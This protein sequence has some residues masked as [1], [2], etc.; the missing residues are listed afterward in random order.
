MKFMKVL[1]NLKILK[2]QKETSY[3]K[4]HTINF[5]IRYLYKYIY[6]VIN[7]L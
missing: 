1:Y 5:T 6:L 3:L 2:I 7:N 4:R